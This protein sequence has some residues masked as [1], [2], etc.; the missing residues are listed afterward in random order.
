MPPTDSGRFGQTAA[1]VD[2]LAG[3]AGRSQIQTSAQLIEQRLGVLE[4]GGVEISGE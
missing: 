2:H 1:V 3:P 4:I